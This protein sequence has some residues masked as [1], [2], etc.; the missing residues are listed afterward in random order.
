MKIFFMYL[1]I[2]TFHVTRQDEN[3]IN[4]FR[5][6]YTYF[7]YYVLL[8]RKKELEICLESKL[9]TLQIDINE[10]IECVRMDQLFKKLFYE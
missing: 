9:L 1:N 5:E 3:E 2:Q 6:I 8:C 7:S 4:L 10:P